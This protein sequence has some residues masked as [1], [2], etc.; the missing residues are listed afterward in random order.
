MGR[1]GGS[2]KRQLLTAS[3][4]EAERDGHWCSGHFLS[5][6][7]FSISAQETVL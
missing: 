6:V 3:R 4:Q 2:T 7:Q 5:F 1:H